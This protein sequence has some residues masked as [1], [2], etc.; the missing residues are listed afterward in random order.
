MA[1][2]LSNT[3]FCSNDLVIDLVVIK[4]LDIFSKILTKKIFFTYTDKKNNYVL[5]LKSM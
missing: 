2:L 5:L 3:P 4:F 1:D